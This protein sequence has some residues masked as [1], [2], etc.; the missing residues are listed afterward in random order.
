[1]CVCV[2]VV[3][4]V[5]GISKDYIVRFEDGDLRIFCVFI[6][7]SGLVCVCVCVF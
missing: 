6:L 4:S 3:L 2:C 5:S 7:C 1:M